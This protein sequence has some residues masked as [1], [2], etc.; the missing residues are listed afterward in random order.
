MTEVELATFAGGCFWNFVEMPGR[1]R[2]LSL[3]TPQGWALSGINGLL[4]DPGNAAAIYLPLLV[5]FST[6][7]I[8][9]PLSYMMIFTRT[10]TR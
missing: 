6:A 9:L 5:L 1:V 4:T 7:L 3:L 2:Q 10:I 8:L